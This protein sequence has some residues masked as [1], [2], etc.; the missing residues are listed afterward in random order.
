MIFI[1]MKVNLSGWILLS[2][3]IV[4]VRISVVSSLAFY[5]CFK[6]IIGL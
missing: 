2:L 3:K 1:N 4:I 5:Y 6:I